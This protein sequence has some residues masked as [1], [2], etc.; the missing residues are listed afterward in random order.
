VRY[1]SANY[2]KSTDCYETDVMKPVL[3]IFKSP[4][5][6]TGSST[7]HVSRNSQCSYPRG[8]LLTHNRRKVLGLSAR[9]CWRCL[10]RVPSSGWNC[11]HSYAV[12]CLPGCCHPQL[13][14]RLK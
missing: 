1:N 4:L 10:V 7:L 6:S 12:H 14:V 5:I 8:A 2:C 3:D 11:C 9:A 13:C